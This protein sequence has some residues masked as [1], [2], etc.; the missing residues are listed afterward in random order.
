MIRNIGN[1]RLK[2][3]WRKLEQ[4][5]RRKT[6]R[7]DSRL[8]HA[9]VLVSVSLVHLPCF[10]RSPGGRD[11]R[12]FSQP[13]TH[14]PPPPS[15]PYTS[16][17]IVVAVLSPQLHTVTSF[18]AAE[19]K[20]NNEH[21][22]FRSWTSDNL[23]HCKTRSVGRRKLVGRVV[24]TPGFAGQILGENCEQVRGCWGPG[25]IMAQL[26]SVSLVIGVYTVIM[27]RPA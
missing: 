24:D 20:T 4:K 23:H 26:Q 5:P 22:H 18:Q 15:S 10:H 21:H 19:V 17:R 7:D 25:G 6:R 9:L 2:K 11:I 12:V 16:H 14:T 1:L 27:S 13:P 8:S 3:T